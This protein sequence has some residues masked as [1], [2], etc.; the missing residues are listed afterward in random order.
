MSEKEE[1]DCLCDKTSMNA[2][3]LETLALQMLPIVL[4]IDKDIS[5]LLEIKHNRCE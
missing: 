5:L 4:F 2:F 3:V 1:F